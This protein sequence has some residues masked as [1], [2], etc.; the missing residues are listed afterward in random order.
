MAMPRRLPP[1]KEI[2]LLIADT[3]RGYRRAAK[4]RADLLEEVELTPTSTEKSQRM[5]K[6][7]IALARICDTMS[8]ELNALYELKGRIAQEANQKLH[9]VIEQVDSPWNKADNGKE[10]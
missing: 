3:L 6:M 1:E 7:A 9:I 4:Y 5:V 8:R 2:Q 10:A